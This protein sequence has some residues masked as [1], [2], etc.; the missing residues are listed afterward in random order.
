MTTNTRIQSVLVLH[1]GEMGSAIGAR[2]RERG[3]RVGWVSEGRSDASRQRA[4]AAGLVGHARLAEGLAA[5]DLVLSVCPPDAAMAQAQQ[6]IGA[7][8]TGIYVDANATS[9]ESSADIGRRIEAAGAT[10]VDAAII[11]PPPQGKTSTRLYLSGPIAETLAGQLTAEPLSA[12]V[13]P[14]PAGSASALKMC[15]AGWNKAML[16]LLGEVRALADAHQVT[17]ALYAEWELMDPDVMPRLES[18][19][20]NTRK[21]WRWS[22]EMEE[23]AVTMADAGL[24]NGSHLA[25]A[26]VYR[27]LAGFKDTPVKPSLEEIGQALLAPAKRRP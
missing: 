16:A 1:P 26:E 2:W 22:G 3:L 24:P 11:G 25:A 4:Q 9:P 10:Y 15:F 19:R 18:L 8:F 5:S 13:V 27:R 6:V 23:V 14:G 7:G 12:R 21:A 17:E 20:A